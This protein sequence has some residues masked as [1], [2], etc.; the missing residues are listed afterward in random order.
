MTNPEDKQTLMELVK[1][2]IHSKVYNMLP[3]GKVTGPGAM[4]KTPSSRKKESE[5]ELN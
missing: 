2:F 5:E 3:S 4:T 1:T